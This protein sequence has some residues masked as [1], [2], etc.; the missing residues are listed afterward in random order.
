M[1]H[2]DPTRLTVLALHT[3][4]PPYFE[5]SVTYSQ[6]TKPL[7]NFMVGIDN[8]LLCQVICDHVVSPLF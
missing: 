3:I 7:E 8:A 2:H 6:L 5:S 4:N 1:L